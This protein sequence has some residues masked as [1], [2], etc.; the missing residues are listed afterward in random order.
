MGAGEGFLKLTKEQLKQLEGK[1]PD[2][3]KAQF[4]PPAATY[5]EKASKVL[6][7][8]RSPSSSNYRLRV[9]GLDSQGKV[10]NIWNQDYID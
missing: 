2:E 1:S 6:R 4:G 5:E 9:I 7:Y 3:V 8:S 10:V